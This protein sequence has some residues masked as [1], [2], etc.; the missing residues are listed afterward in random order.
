MRF[1]S[2]EDWDGWRAPGIRAGPSWRSG[3][4][5]IRREAY[6]RRRGYAT[7]VEVRATLIPSRV[8]GRLVGLDPAAARPVVIPL[9]AAI[10]LSCL[11]VPLS[12]GGPLEIIA[13]IFICFSAAYVFAGSIGWI[14]KPRNLT[15][16]VLMVIGLCGAFSL[17]GAAPIPWIGTVTQL[18]ATT[19]TVLLFLVLLISPA[20]R[21][22]SRLD[23]IG[24]VVL[25]VT[26]S[27][28]VVLRPAFL[29]GAIP[30]ILGLVSIALL[31]LVLRRWLLASGPTRRSLGP[32]A[33]AGAITASIFLMNSISISFGIPNEP[34]SLVFAVDAVGRAL[35][36]FG[37]LAGLIRLRMARIAI[38][39][40]VTELGGLPAPE[41]LRDALASALG[42]R[43]L[44]V[45]HWSPSAGAY[46]TAD[47]SPVQLPDE[48][49]HRAV[50]RLEHDGTPI[51][52]IVHDAA[53]QEDPGL[54][55]AVAAA[56]RLTVENERLAARVQTQLE[57]V[58][59]SRTRIIEAGDAERKRVER[60][61]HDGAQQRLVSLA[62]ALRLAR[63]RLGDRVDPAA[64]ETLDQA[65]A[66]AKAALGELRELARG[67]HPAILTEAGLGAAV[68]SLADRSAVPVSVEGATAERFAPPV[69]GTAYFVV[70]EGLANV[71]KYARATHASV[72]LRREPDA[73]TVEIF[74]DG[75]GDADPSRGSG[76]NGLVDR[77]AAVNGTLEIQSPTGAGTRLTAHIPIPAGSH[78]P[79]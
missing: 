65:S 57:E 7:M 51:A 1:A 41:R 10:S 18:S 45:G 9:V 79:G 15:G 28:T 42:D 68:Q 59:A 46:L 22:A 6:A 36:P 25:A 35:I 39:D 52:V 70:S 58:R 8:G 56:V 34:G 55:A 61:L 30:L 40:L 2:D 44:Q 19:A 3:T 71:N 54:V 32:I 72:R 4:A 63:V 49:R 47:G 74:D 38:A 31:M 67:I 37:F 64:L 20:G 73:L 77:L 75:V 66:E 13:P 17:L 50:T 76:L 26:Y 12:R 78:L 11:A 14:L 24:F 33:A 43:T 27:T 29:S 69:Q 48:D 16:P 5:P 53:L 60:D 62:L 21:F 23:V